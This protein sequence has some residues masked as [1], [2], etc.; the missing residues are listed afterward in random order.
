MS[1]PADLAAAGQQLVTALGGRWHQ[2]RGICRCPAHDDRVASLSVRIGERTLLFKCFAGCETS[3][4]LAAL[5]AE[6]RVVPR[7]ERRQPVFITP[8][9]G[10]LVRA[11]WDEAFPLQQTIGAAYLRSR[12]LFVHPPALRFHPRTPRG[13]GRAVERRPAILAA[14][15]GDKGLTALQRLFLRA[16]GLGLARDLPEARLCL[17]RL[18]AG[19]VRLSAVEAELGLA[20]GI[21]TALSATA[22]LGIPV[23]AVLGSA[24]FHVLSL[25]SQVRTVV[26]LPDSDRAGRIAAEKAHAAYSRC[27]LAVRTEWPWDGHND[28][29][30]VLR[31][32]CQQEEREKGWG[33]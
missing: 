22:L 8:R 23:W 24:R 20:E 13:R 6:N 2:D 4:V 28:W 11:L 30:D 33:G 3:A 18:W 29:N 14:V 21:E 9:S 5:R 12:N 26:L 15:A 31:R 1:F 32:R 25:P 19:A 7:Q 16:D 10:M 17:G 27:G